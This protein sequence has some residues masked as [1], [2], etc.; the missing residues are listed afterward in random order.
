MM[1]QAIQEFDVIIIGGGMVGGC[2]ALA[3]TSAGTSGL[4]V[5]IVEAQSASVKQAA[6]GGKR[7]IALSWGSRCLLQQMGLWENVQSAAMP[8]ENIHISDRG[9]FGKTRLSAKVQKVDA[10]GYVVEAAQI[11]ANIDQ[12]L[13]QLVVT[14]KSSAL[15]IF[16]P[17]ELLEYH[18]DAQGVLVTLKTGS[19]QQQ[20]RCQLLVGADGGQ[21]KVRQQGDFILK[22]NDYQ[23][24]AITTLLEVESDEHTIA[25]ERFTSEGPIAMLPHFDGLYSLVW[26][27]P[28]G[29]AQQVKNLD[30]AEFIER[31]QTRFGGW[32]GELSLAGA[33]QIFPLQ[34]SHVDDSVAERVALIG[35]AAHQLHP[36][37][38]QG[39]N[40]GLRDAAQ[41]ADVVLNAFANKQDIASFE[42]LQ[43]Y[44]AH[45][46][47]DQQL[48]IGFTDNIIKLFSNENALLSV[49]R[50]SGLLLLDKYPFLKRQFARQTMGLGA[51]LPRLNTG[52]RYE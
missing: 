5:A 39:F 21:S 2:L 35:N 33:R 47:Q 18:V 51:R 32:L 15:E 52:S 7:A 50:N 44:S 3:L 10:L 27:M 36:V 34:L 6:A 24:M 12:Q 37:A 4:R 31:L 28:T 42:T 11:E 43:A 14:D 20:L 16:R 40:L 22:E 48:I 49:T 29:T 9:H 19:E 45:R 25:Y 26:T 17:A 41:L 13:D 23:Q 8:I 1:Q 38:G 30:D 46:K